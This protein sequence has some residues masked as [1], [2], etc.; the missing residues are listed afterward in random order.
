MK[1]R[2]LI[3]GGGV[4]ATLSLGTTATSASLAE[5]ISVP[6]DFHVIDERDETAS[7]SLADSTQFDD[8]THTW[9]NMQFASNGIAVT[10]ISVDYGEATDFADDGGFN[11][12]DEG[13]ITIEFWAAQQGQFREPDFTFSSSDAATATFDIDEDDNDATIENSDDDEDTNV[14]IE[15]SGF[16]NPETGSYEPTLTFVGADGDVVTVGGASFTTGSGDGEFAVE[17]LDAPDII[18]LDERATVEVEVENVGFGT[19][20][21]EITLEVDGSEVDSASVEEL[22]ATET[23]TV[24]LESDQAD[25]TGILDV[26]VSSDD[27]TDNTSI[28]VSG[29][30]FL[31]LEDTG[32]STDSVH[33]WR[34]FGIDFDGEIDTIDIEYLDGTQQGGRLE[35]DEDDTD[36]TIELT[37]E[38]ES[39]PTEIEDFEFTVPNQNSNRAEITLDD[40]TDTTIAGAA[41]IEIDDLRHPNQGGDYEAAIELTGDDRFD[42]TV[43]YG[44]E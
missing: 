34:T 36:I 37:R 35:F 23:E 4:L 18:G 31:E 43:T 16:E 26:V 11:S 39:E 27:D 5:G 30:W 9:D 44:I 40:S 2:N 42:E 41:L 6:T 29:G 17:I 33:T 38:G 7:I 21:Q 20:N 10:E 3:L 1:R 22:D 8:T 24:T 32:T 13:D 25:S 28:G 14:I 15:Y 19:D 12:I